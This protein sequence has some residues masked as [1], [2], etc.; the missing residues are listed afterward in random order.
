MF[1]AGRVQS[2]AL[3]L[4]AE[5]ESEIQAFT[6]Q[7]YWTVGAT[8]QAPS[9]MTFQVGVQACIRNLCNALRSVCV[10]QSVCIALAM[11]RPGSRKL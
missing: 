9:G 4:V 10:H 11:V 3:R 6:T 1:H 2:V 8:L 7:H 5:R